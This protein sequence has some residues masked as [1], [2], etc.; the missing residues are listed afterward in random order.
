[1]A[2]LDL[3]EL[4][5]GLDHVVLMAK[6]VGKDELAACVHE[7][8][9]GVVALVALGNAGLDEEVG[10]LL[11]DAQARARL[12]K[13]LNKVEVVGGVLVVQADKADLDGRALTRATV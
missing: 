2:E 5:G 10:A 1:M 3:R 12:L 13:R 11:L 8:G 7:L 6:G 4:L 9:R